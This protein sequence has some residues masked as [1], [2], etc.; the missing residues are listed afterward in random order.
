MEP[1]DGQP[2]SDGHVA[3]VRM[4]HVSP[5]TTMMAPTTASSNCTEEADHD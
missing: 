3:I 4:F 2:C 1:H 5:M